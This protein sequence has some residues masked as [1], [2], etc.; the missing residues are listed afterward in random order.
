[1]ATH[2]RDL[3]HSDPIALRRY[4]QKERQREIGW[5]GTVAAGAHL[6]SA[7]TEIYSGQLDARAAALDASWQETRALQDEAVIQDTLLEGMAMAE[8]AQAQSGSAA[9]VQYALLARSAAGE[10][11]KLRRAIK[12]RARLAATQDLAAG[13]RARRQSGERAFGYARGAASALSVARER[14]D[15]VGV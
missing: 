13:A 10:A 3:T 6:F 5:L 4:E 1:M 11:Q 12:L 14:M 7:A 15:A 9:A 2:R 8:V